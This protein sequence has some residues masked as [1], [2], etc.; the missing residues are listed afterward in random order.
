[1]TPHGMTQL[2]IE[3]WN[4][5]ECKAMDEKDKEIAKLLRALRKYGKHEFGCELEYTSVPLAKCNCGLDKAL[6]KG[7]V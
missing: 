1:M 2:I 4:R 5:Q 6:R 3:S 7:K